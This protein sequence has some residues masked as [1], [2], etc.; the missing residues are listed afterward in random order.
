MTENMQ[1]LEL[2]ERLSLIES[3]IAEG[4]RGTES[5]AWVYLLWGVAYYVAFAWSVVGQSWLGGSSLAWLVT[6]TVAALVTVIM[7]RRKARNHPRTA[8]GRAIGS[9]WLT[10]GISLF[11]LMFSLDYS[12]SLNNHVSLA[13]IG[14][15]L[16]VANGASGIILR[17]KMQFACALVWLAAAEVGCFGTEKQ[18]LIAFLAATFFCQIVFG[19]YAMIC[20]SRRRRQGGVAHA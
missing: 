11:V 17:W 9:I 4:R 18:G 20:E 7:K 14:S 3:M 5:W 15:M 13:I 12:G 19:V 10:M 8:I 1:N 16:A 6:M 2:Q